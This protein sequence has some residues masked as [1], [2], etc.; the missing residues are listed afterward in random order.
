MAADMATV[1]TSGSFRDLADVPEDVDTQ[2]SED[3]VDEFVENNG[4]AMASDMASVA[5]SGSYDDLTGAP[6]V[7]G[8]NL[9]HFSSSGTFRVPAGITSLTV[10]VT[11]GGGGGA[12]GEATSIDLGTHSHGVADHT[13]SGGSHSHD[14]GEHTH[15]ST[16]GSSTSWDPCASYSSYSG[17]CVGGYVTSGGGTSISGSATGIT[18]DTSIST[19][20]TE[21]T[22][23]DS[24]S[25]TASVS[26]VGG[27]G[28]SGGG[29]S[30]LL[31]VLPEVEC[32]IT[33][34]TGGDVGSNGTTTAISCGDASTECDG[35]STG[36]DDGTFGR[37][38]SCLVTGGGVLSQFKASHQAP[39][40]GGAG[41]LDLTATAGSD[42]SVTVRY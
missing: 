39:G 29:M 25:T 37:D 21:L 28:G 34:G 27:D 13:H 16:S 41:G 8:V 6:P 10:Y 36:L 18:G 17:R 12:N 1:A 9:E 11:G 32:T 2:L 24:D 33:I 35:G 3:E 40:G 14:S 38:G 30:A 5:T 20:S 42:G 23:N 22:I 7:V 4:Y 31:T 26:H 19:G 15:S